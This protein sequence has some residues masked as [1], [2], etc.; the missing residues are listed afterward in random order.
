MKKHI[1]KLSMLTLC[2]SAILA[3]PALSRAQDTTNA[4]GRRRANSVGQETQRHAC[5]A[6]V[7]RHFDRGGHE[8]DD[9]DG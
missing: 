4:P 3:V 6:A 5:H 7:P 2:A 8:R 1:A 9:P